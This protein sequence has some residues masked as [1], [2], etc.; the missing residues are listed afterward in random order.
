VTVALRNI[1]AWFFQGRPATLGLFGILMM[2]G[3]HVHHMNQEVGVSLGRPIL[4]L[5]GSRA[6]GASSTNSP[7]P[8]SVISGGQSAELVGAKTSASSSPQKKDLIQSDGEID[9]LNLSPEDFRV[10]Q[11][12]VSHRNDL[13]KKEK[14]ITLQNDRLQAFKKLLQ[15]KLTKLKKLHLQLKNQITSLEQRNQKDLQ[16]LGKMFEGMK[17]Q[18]A[19]QI[20]LT[21]DLQIALR[22]IRHMK[23]A[24]A[25]AILTSLP[26]EQAAQLTVA[27]AQSSSALKPTRDAEG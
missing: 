19:A 13:Q 27:L 14:E 16:D 20:F 21:L 25:S 22:L 10:L 4:S 15:Q 18:E 11:F 7:V 2:M 23:S 5:N 8:S 9:L 3:V 24:K 26:P 6:H 1:L 17:P 12:L